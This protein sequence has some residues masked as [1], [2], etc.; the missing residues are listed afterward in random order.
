M[1]N[2]FKRQPMNDLNA[3][4]EENLSAD[5]LK[6]LNLTALDGWLTQASQAVAVPEGFQNSLQTKLL[7]ANPITSPER[8]TRRSAPRMAWI[9]AGLALVAVIV[10]LVVPAL[11]PTSDPGTTPAAVASDQTKT[12]ETPTE[13]APLEKL[14]LSF[15]SDSAQAQSGQEGIFGQ[16]ELTLNATFPAGPNEAPVYEQSIEE[17]MSPEQ[18]K[19]LAASLGI[20]GNV[21]T[22]S[23]EGGGSLYHVTDGIQEIWFID[24]TTHFTFLADF[25]SGVT[26]SANPLPLT[27]RAAAAETFLKARGLLDFDYQVNETLSQDNRV[28]FTRLLSDL[29]LRE[30]D[31]YNPYIEVTLDGQGA[32]VSVFYRLNQMNSLGNYPLRSAQEAWNLVLGDPNDKR[33]KY[34]VTLP[35]MSVRNRQPAWERTYPIGQQVELYSYLSVLQPTEPGGEPWVTVSGFTLQGDL[36]GLLDAYENPPDLTAEQKEKI[37]AGIISEKQ[38][39]GWVRFF[40]IWGQTSQDENGAHYLQVE[41]WEISPMPDMSFA[42]VFREING[43]IQFISEDNQ[44]WTIAD[45]P[46]DLPLETWVRVRGVLSETQSNTFIWSLIQVEVMNELVATGGGGGGGTL[47]FSPDPDATPEPTPTPLPMPYQEGQQVND[48]VGAVSVYRLVKSDGSKVTTAYLWAPVPNDPQDFRYYQLMGENL[49]ELD[50]LNQLHIR[51][52]GTY[53]TDKGEPAIELQRFEKAYPEETI[54]AWLGHQEVIELGGRPVLQ[55]TDIN[56]QQ[57]ILAKSLNMPEEL[58]EDPFDGT[59][60]II[61]GVIAQETY[62]GLPMITEFSGQIAVGASDLSNYTIKSG[63]VYEETEQPDLLSNQTANSI[64]IDTVELVYYAYDLSHGGGGLPLDES[65]ARFVQPVW[66][67]S[68]TLSDGRLV[69]VLV[70]AV[71]DEYLH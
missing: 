29:P 12:P 55:F 7:K 49:Q 3:P 41:G 65:P 57:Y 32:V 17:V 50:S 36:T 51:V 53:T 8:P 21:Y 67:F 23:S 48:L 54:R 52:W 71:T 46:A 35:E 16:A 43:E 45:L 61:E 42:G 56:G 6:A 37:A 47:E 60:C 4:L 38:A 1:N 69:E 39:A 13:Q 28:I 25:G 34:S 27:E 31:A 58:I 66:R 10:A 30:T 14:L 15:L 19:A 9:A 22:T 44:Q 26:S 33:V 59:Q 5:E 62:E 24:T 70:Q 64:N 20:E 2:P 68:G 18:A 40:H 11:R 63:L